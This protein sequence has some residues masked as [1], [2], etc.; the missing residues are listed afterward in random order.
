MPPRSAN[1]LPAEAA[2]PEAGFI[3]LPKVLSLLP[4][5]RS[6]WWAGI[7]S[8]RYPAPVKIGPRLSAW[9]VEDIRELLKTLS[10]QVPTAGTTLPL[11]PR[12]ALSRRSDTT[13]R[14]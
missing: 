3:R 13:A 10:S 4:I 5:G 7:R 2:L 11:P 9:R 6:T 8:G 12:V 14:T 1:P